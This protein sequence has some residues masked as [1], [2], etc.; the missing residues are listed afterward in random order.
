MKTPE[1]ARSVAVMERNDIRVDAC[2][3]RHMMQLALSGA[4]MTRTSI[5]PSETRLAERLAFVGDRPAFGD[6]ETHH[7]L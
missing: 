2:S 5:S 4:V 3:V 7:A 6:T 1:L